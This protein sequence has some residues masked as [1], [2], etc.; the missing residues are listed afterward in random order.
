[1]LSRPSTLLLSFYSTFFPRR[2]LIIEAEN[3]SLSPFT[4]QKEEKKHKYAP[5]ARMTMLA[6]SLPHPGPIVNN[7]C[8][9]LQRFELLVLSKLKWDVAAVTPQDFLKHL[10]N[11]LDVQSVGISY[12]LVQ[13]HAKTLITLCSRGTYPPAASDSFPYC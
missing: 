9:L 1:M 4:C 7:H 12:E 10:L 3:S 6:S 13:K 2:I 8:F 11:K 5:V